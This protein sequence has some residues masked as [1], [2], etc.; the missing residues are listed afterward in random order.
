MI[1]FFR[2]PANSFIATE[3]DHKPSVEDIQKL[4]WLYGEANALEEESINGIFILR[5]A[6]EKVNFSENRRFSLI[7]SDF[8]RDAV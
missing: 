2:T 6:P 4:C 7:S 8:G 3:F 5:P 1:Q